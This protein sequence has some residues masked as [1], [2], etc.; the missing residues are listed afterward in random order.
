MT[1][2]QKNR[3]YVRCV[4]QS[5]FVCMCERKKE[6]KK[7]ISKE[8]KENKYEEN[9]GPSKTSDFLLMSSS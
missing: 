4:C 1:I 3:A 6:R 5:V 9:I 7:D 8:D 2:R